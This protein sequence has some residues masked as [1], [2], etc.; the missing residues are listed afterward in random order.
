MAMTSRYQRIVGLGVLDILPTELRTRIYKAYF[1][2][3]II[4]AERN[5]LGMRYHKRYSRGLLLVSRTVYQEARPFEERADVDLDLQ[6]VVNLFLPASLAKHC[7]LLRIADLSLA[8]DWKFSASTSLRRINFSRT[9]RRITAI[10][11]TLKL[12]TA[13]RV[14]DCLKGELDAEMI[15]ILRGKWDS[16]LSTTRTAFDWK[17]VPAG[18]IT[19]FE[20]TFY[21]TAGRISPPY[22]VGCKRKLDSQTNAF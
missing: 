17:T 16:M 15:Q 19:V 7:T 20:P 21:L 18:I 1:S 10:C 11:G 13:E 9:H 8:T 5:G 6:S 14:D 2:G 4:Q 3:R 12:A 22:L